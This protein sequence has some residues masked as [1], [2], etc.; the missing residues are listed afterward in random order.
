MP[1]LEEDVKK[2]ATILDAFLKDEENDSGFHPQMFLMVAIG[3]QCGNRAAAFSVAGRNI[4]A[5]DHLTMACIAQQEVGRKYAEVREEQEQ[6]ATGD[7]YIGS[8]EDYMN[9]FRRQKQQQTQINLME[10][11]VNLNGS[12][13][14][15]HRY[16]YTGELTFHDSDAL[17]NDTHYMVEGEVMHNPNIR[18][19]IKMGFVYVHPL[20]KEMPAW[21]ESD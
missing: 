18:T 1:T 12:N 16:N 3:T 19:T 13:A 11:E 15:P 21:Q 2:A 17:T 20:G 5:L 14:S 6:P 7:D 4:D 10:L 9:W 8:F